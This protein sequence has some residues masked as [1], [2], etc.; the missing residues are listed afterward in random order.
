MTSLRIRTLLILTSTLLLS[1]CGKSELVLSSYD[2]SQTVT[3]NVEVADSVKERTKGLMNRTSLEKDSGMLFV[4]PEGQMLSFWMKD[5]KIPLEIMFF[6]QQ[7]S[8]VNS[9]VMQPCT[10][11]PCEPYKSAAISNY[12]L[13]VLPGFREEH[14][15]GVGWKLDPHA[16]AKISNPS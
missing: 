14:G 8:F 1:A 15:I 16:V 11:D 7:G 6:D 5:T 2:G 10:E 9:Y 12:A 4:F 13:E 3:V